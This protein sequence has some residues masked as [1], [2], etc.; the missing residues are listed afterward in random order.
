MVGDCGAVPVIQRSRI[1]PG[2]HHDPFLGERMLNDLLDCD[3]WYLFLTPDGTLLAWIHRIK[4]RG[5]VD[6]N[7]YYPPLV[8]LSYRAGPPRQAAN[9]CADRRGGRLGSTRGM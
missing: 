5:S 2:Q 4:R 7:G 3:H 8:S 1:V 9:A 6:H